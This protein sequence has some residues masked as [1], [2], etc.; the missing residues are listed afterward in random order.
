MGTGND[1]AE[2]ELLRALE[3]KTTLA[4]K[5]RG[6]DPAVDI[7][8]RVNDVVA[9]LK[10]R[11]EEI[12][13]PIMKGDLS[14]VNKALAGMLVLL[15]I[16]YAIVFL[17]GVRKLS[18]MPHFGVVQSK[19]KQASAVGSLFGLKDYSYYVDK[20]I[21]RNIFNPF[22]EKK[23]IVNTGVSKLSELAKS[24]RVA[25]ISWAEDIKDRYVMIEDVS[26][27]ITYFL[28]EGDKVLGIDVKNI[29]KDHISLSYMNDA[30]ELR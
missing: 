6:G 22:E 11:S 8:A 27:K 13:G 2:K 7:A 17:N 26:S 20:L 24:L 15:A 9:D 5:V 28:K 30:M 23:V 25:G 3:G 29:Y 18:N 14:S 1:S 4:A 12:I 10:K 21:N 16:V 19:A